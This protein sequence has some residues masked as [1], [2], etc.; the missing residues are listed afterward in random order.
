MKVDFKFIG[1]NCHDNHDKVWGFFTVDE[2]VTYR[3]PCYIFWGKRGGS[4]RFKKD[5]IGSAIYG[6]ESSKMK[7]GYDRISEAQLLK[8][9]P[10]FYDDLE[11]RLS[12]LTLANKVM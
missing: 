3:Q 1:W 11:A 6:L 4:M 5:V 10:D 7:K 12:W 8:I 2:S 9:W